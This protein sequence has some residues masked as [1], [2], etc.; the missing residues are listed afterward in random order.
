[1]KTEE[2]ASGTVPSPAN[3]N[4]P[5]GGRGSPESRAEGGLDP[6]IRIIA[7]AIG[8]HIAREHIRA[9]ERTRRRQAAND[10]A[11]PEREEEGRK[12]EG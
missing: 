4:G 8:H 7:R 10:N 9:W 5:S 11:T 12:P 3:D 6:R 1:M 2:P